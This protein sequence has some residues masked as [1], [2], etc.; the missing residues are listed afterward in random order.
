[1]LRAGTAGARL[2]SGRQPG[3]ELGRSRGRPDSIAVDR[4]GNIDAGE[5]INGNWLQEFVN[6]GMGGAATD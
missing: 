1:M 4:T 2:R 3:Q 5:T 6:K